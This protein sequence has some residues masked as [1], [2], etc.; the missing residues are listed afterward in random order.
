[1]TGNEHNKQNSYLP[2]ALHDQ[3]AGREGMRLSGSGSRT[4]ADEVHER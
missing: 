2:M 4:M 1:M 3:G